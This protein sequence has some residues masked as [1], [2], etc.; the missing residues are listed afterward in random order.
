[1]QHGHFPFLFKMIQ[2]IFT[3]QSSLLSYSTH[4]LQLSDSDGS[5]K[6]RQLAS[7]SSIGSLRFSSALGLDHETF[8]WVT[9]TELENES[10]M[11]SKERDASLWLTLDWCGVGMAVNAISPSVAIQIPLYKIYCPRCIFCTAYLF[12]PIY[13]LMLYRLA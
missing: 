12:P 6:L 8:Y 11:Q 1:M 3:N 10:Y 4:I 7:I 2:S 13:L 5:C 9:E